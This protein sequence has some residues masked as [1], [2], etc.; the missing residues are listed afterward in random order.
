MYLSLREMRHAR[1]RTAMIVSIIALIAWLVFLLSGLANGLSN[2]NGASLRKMDAIGIVYQHWV[3][4]SVSIRLLMRQWIMRLIGQPAPG[5]AGSRSMGALRRPVK[6][7]YAVLAYR[8]A[9]VRG[10]PR[11]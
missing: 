11:P 10:R 4:D 9:R 7:T 3:A 1:L 8:F 6:K 2:D 5:G